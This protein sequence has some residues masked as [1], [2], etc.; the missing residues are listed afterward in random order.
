[1]HKL[2]FYHRL[3]LFSFNFVVLKPG[4]HLQTR[5]LKILFYET[6]ISFY[7]SLEDEQIINCE[8]E[9]EEDEDDTAFI[10]LVFKNNKHILYMHAYISIILISL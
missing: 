7:A 5:I 1:M 10:A 3:R 8:T 4:Q 6:E 2:L 9:E